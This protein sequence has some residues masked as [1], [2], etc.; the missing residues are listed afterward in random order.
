MDQIAFTFWSIKLQ[1]KLFFLNKIMESKVASLTKSCRGFQIT[2]NEIAE[3]GDMLMY[4]RGL[5]PNYLLVGK[6]TDPTTGN[7]HAHIYVQFVNA[8]RL[9]LKKLLGAHIEKCFGSPQQNIAYIKK[10][11]TEIVVEEGEV[12]KKGGLRFLRVMRVEVEDEAPIEETKLEDKEITNKMKGKKLTLIGEEL[13]LA[14]YKALIIPLEKLPD[15][16]D[17]TKEI[18]RD[19]ISKIV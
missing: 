18:L 14:V 10:P 11:D 17:K 7:K 8:R 16:D 9:S 3:L 6:E 12:R 1:G 5:N 13:R 15:T 4:L 2:C 19:R